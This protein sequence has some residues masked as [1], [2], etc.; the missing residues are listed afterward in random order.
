MKS[1]IDINVALNMTAEQKLEEIS[2]PVENL[3]LMLSALTK[4][5][6]DHPLSGDELTALLN[7][8]HKQVLDIQ[9]AI[10]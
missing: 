8:L 3:Q 2:Y 4:M 5:H 9:R 10:K 1:V 6:L 7:T